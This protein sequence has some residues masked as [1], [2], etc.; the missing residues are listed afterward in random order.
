MT[1]SNS[2]FDSV[3]SGSVTF[4]SASVEET[5]S[6]GKRLADSIPRPSCVAFFGD[7]GAGKTSLIRGYTAARIGINPYEVSSPTFQLLHLYEG[8]KG[9]LHH[10][11]LWRLEG[12]EDFM[13]LGFHEYLMGH[14]VCLEWAEKLPT[15]L[16]REVVRVELEKHPKDPEKRVIVVTWTGITLNFS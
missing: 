9:D 12:E 7:M 16:P 15:L 2:P 5:E 1:L 8:P 11:D 14:D 10:F 13:S 4:G 6:I 3:S